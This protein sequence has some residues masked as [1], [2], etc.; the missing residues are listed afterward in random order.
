MIAGTCLYVIVTTWLLYGA[1]NIYCPY[2]QALRALGSVVSK[3]DAPYIEAV[4]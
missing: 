3:R 4:W 2:P 1:Y